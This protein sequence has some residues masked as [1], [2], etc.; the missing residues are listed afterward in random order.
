MKDFLVTTSKTNETIFAKAGDM[1]PSIC[2][3]ERVRSVMRYS[4]FGKGIQVGLHLE[5]WWATRGLGR[6]DGIPL[7]LNV[8]HGTS[9]YALRVLEFCS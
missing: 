1:N 7:S 5:A 3:N 9:L 2:V 6:W 4:A 8:P